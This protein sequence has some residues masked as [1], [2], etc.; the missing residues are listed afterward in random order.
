MTSP[1]QICGDWNKD[2]KLKVIRFFSEL[3]IGRQSSRVNQVTTLVWEMLGWAR[4]YNPGLMCSQVFWKEGSFSFKGKLRW[5]DMNWRKDEKVG[6][7]CWWFVR[8]PARKQVEGQVVYLPLFTGFYTS[9]HFWTINSMRSINICF[10]SILDTKTSPQN[11]DATHCPK[12]LAVKKE[13]VGRFL[14]GWRWIWS[15]LCF[16][17]T[18]W[19]P[20]FSFGAVNSIRFF[21]VTQRMQK[22]PL[23][24]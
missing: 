10:L 16:L 14:F 8:N 21:R 12:G 18:P 5:L 4:T 24:S 1:T 7:Y 9:N 11:K 13:I 15:I 19:R 22:L 17:V 3:Q 23:V 20:I 6:I 2:H